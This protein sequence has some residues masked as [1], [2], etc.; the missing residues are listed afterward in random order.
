MYDAIDYAATY[1]V[2]PEAEYPHKPPSVK[3]PP[4]LCPARLADARKLKN[5]V[6]QVGSM[7]AAV[8]L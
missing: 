8:P 5:K 7:F 1:G 3:L 4:T 2:V 6:V